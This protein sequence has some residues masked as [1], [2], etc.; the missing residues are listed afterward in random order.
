MQYR[1]LGKSNLKV[2]A[3]CLGTMM[4]GR[5]TPIEE[6]ARIVASARA[7]G[8]NFIDTADV[9]N[10]GQSEKDLGQLLKGQRQHWVL[11]SK[12]GNPVSE[13]VNQSHYSRRWL[14]QQTEAILARLQ[15]DYLDILY[16][17]RDYHEEN[18]EEAV[19]ALGDL[20]SAGK[21]RSFG[22][23]NFRGWRIAE[24]VRLCKELGVQP[25]SVCQPYYNLLNRGPEVEIL[26]ACG[27]YGLGVVPY[28]PLARGVLTGKYPP[29]QPPAE[30]TRAG[31]GDKRILETEFREES[32]LIAQKIKA[33]CEAR[34]Q[35]PGQFAAAWV[36]ANPLISAVIV[37]PRTLAHLEDVYG[38]LDLTL[39]AEDEAFV[40]ALVVP[41][42][43]SSPGYNDPGY[44][45]FGRPV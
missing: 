11:A 15:T 21:I 18:L 27:H 43:A 37:G 12:L 23:S 32:L 24:V 29:G 28:S 20:I 16:L 35:I 30:G 25:P 14:I 10:Q 41:G 44:P 34:G 8:I 9:Y 42:H 26:P 36:L 6:A 22:L 31:S 2:S 40:N 39:T 13:A 3:L 33:R 17:H 1:R 38:A 4:F 19:R 5:Q 45:F 7:H